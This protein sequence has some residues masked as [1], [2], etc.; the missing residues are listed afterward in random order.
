MEDNHF[1]ILILGSGI[2]GLVTAARIIDEKKE[3][4]IAIINKSNG[5]S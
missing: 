3:A 2:S 1:N 5:S 4:K